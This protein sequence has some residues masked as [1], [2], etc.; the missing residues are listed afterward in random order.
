MLT[1]KELIVKLSINDPAHFLAYSFGIPYFV[2]I[3]RNFLILFAAILLISKE[4]RKNLWPIF[5]V[6]SI[7]VVFKG[8]ILLNYCIAHEGE[9]IISTYFASVDILLT[10]VPLSFA[11]IF[12]MIR[13]KPT[14]CNYRSSKQ[15]IIKE[16]IISVIVGILLLFIML[17]LLNRY[18][19]LPVR[20]NF[21]ADITGKTLWLAIVAFV[22]V[23][24]FVEETI[25]RGFIFNSL[26]TNRDLLFSFITSS[27]IFA[28]FKCGYNIQDGLLLW[29]FVFGIIMAFLAKYSRNISVP[30][31][32]HATFNL[33]VILLNFYFGR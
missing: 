13:N 15:K 26:Q 10:G 25:F 16:S 9:L 31:I 1:I 6:Y 20:V 27:F 28:F 7:F 19:D 4:Y 14:C 30:I 29:L 11:V 17:I 22:F 21:F 33:G 3:S 12:V 23:E 32:T 24:P 5:W 8:I 2:I 18:I